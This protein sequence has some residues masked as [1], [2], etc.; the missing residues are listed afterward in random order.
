LFHISTYDAVNEALGLPEVFSNRFGAVMG[1]QQPSQPVADV[2][3]RGYPPVDTM[4]TQD[5]PEQRRYRRLVNKAFT[6]R[7]VERLA[8]RMREICDGLVD[9]FLPHGHCELLDEFAVKLPLTVIAEQLG[10]PGEELPKFKEWSDGFV[11]QLGQMADEAGQIAAA[12]LILEYQ[13]YFVKKLEERRANPRDDILSNVVNARIEGERP[14]NTAE[15]LSILQQLLVAGNETTAN[16][17]AEGVLYLIQN[18][19]QLALVEADH[20]LIPN[21][22]EEVLRLSSPTANM[23]R[24]AKQDYELCG[25]KIPAGSTVL[26]RYAAANRDEAK[27]K[28]G[29]RFVVTRENAADHIAFGVGVHF[30]LGAILARQEMNIAFQTLFERTKNWALAAGY[31]PVHKPNVLLY[32]LT[33]LPL[34]FEAR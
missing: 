20:S 6:P 23:W 33:E 15:C 14:L 13:Q 7:K 34:E 18:P 12:E 25:T 27:F 5:P 9:A 4:L 29:D 24:V 26:I 1:S 22:V 32:G 2:M 3:R 16:A 28:D 10:V 30:C 11:A 31:Q 8:P 21:L 19:D 17:I